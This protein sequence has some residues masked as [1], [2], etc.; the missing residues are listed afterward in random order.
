[1]IMTIMRRLVVIA[2]L[3]FV[4]WLFILL[5]AGMASDRNR[6]PV[7]WVLLGLI[8]F[9]LLPVILLLM[10]GRRSDRRADKSR[11]A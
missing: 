2:G 9:P 7:A 4:L 11:D 6:S 3:L 5:P 1:M 10:A 8:F